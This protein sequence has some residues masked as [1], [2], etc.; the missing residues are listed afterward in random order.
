[1]DEYLEAMEEGRL[2]DI[3]RANRAASPSLVADTDTDTDNEIITYMPENLT[4][5]ERNFLNNIFNNRNY[6]NL[7]YTRRS[8]EVK[9]SIK[10]ALLKLLEER[11][12]NYI[13]S[14]SL[15]T[16]SQINNFMK[17]CYDEV[18]HE[19]YRITINYKNHDNPR[20]YPFIFLLTKTQHKNNNKAKKNKS[21]YTIT[22]SGNHFKK[23]CRQTLDLNTRF[24]Y[25]LVTKKVLSPINMSELKKDLKKIEKLLNKIDSSE[26]SQ[27]YNDL[28][29]EKN[30]IKNN[31]DSYKININVQS[32][33]FTNQ[34]NTPK[35]LH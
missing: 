30:K 20:Y 16:E 15:L 17:K 27:L 32:R 26:Y 19:S 33:F 6:L 34:D 1:M 2:I 14:L 31:I 18:Q 10:K 5:S 25:L 22:F 24:N 35:K 29:E 28:V 21:K 4:R 12:D 23:T 9:E 3:A 7:K 13:P 11:I 8:K